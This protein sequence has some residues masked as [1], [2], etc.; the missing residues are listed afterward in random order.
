MKR[1]SLRTFFIFIPMAFSTWFFV[2]N[3]WGMII[4]NCDER[5]LNK[6]W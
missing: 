6:I 4:Y 3:G 2:E 5:I 1:S